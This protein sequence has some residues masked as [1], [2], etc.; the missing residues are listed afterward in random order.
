LFSSFEIANDLLNIDR[1]LTNLVHMVWCI[2]KPHDMH[3]S[4]M[5]A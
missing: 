2:Y 1:D 4:I 5:F 3:L